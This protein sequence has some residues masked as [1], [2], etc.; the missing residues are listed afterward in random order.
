MDFDA[1]TGGTGSGN[2]YSGPGPACINNGSATV[3]LCQ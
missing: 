2:S 3:D 1:N